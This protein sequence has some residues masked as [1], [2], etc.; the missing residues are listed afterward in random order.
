MDYFNGSTEIPKY[1]RMIPYSEIKANDFKL[2]I[3]RYIDSSESED[4][5]D[6]S[7]HLFGGIPKKD[8]DVLESY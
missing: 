3:P 8:I 6:I 2:N 1:S 7:A 5:Q 4:L